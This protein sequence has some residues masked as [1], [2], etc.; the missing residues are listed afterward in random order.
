MTIWNDAVSGVLFSIVTAFLIHAI[1]HG[2]FPMPYHLHKYVTNYTFTG[3]IF[4]AIVAP[5][6]NFEMISS[7]K[8]N[9]FS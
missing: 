5:L 7:Q 8:K 4:F 2:M 9:F 3:L 1:L 6:R